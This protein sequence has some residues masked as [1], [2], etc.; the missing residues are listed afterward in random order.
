MSTSRPPDAGTSRG[1]PFFD[2]GLFLLHLNRG[3]EH[4]K[5]GLFDDARREFEDARRFRSQDP[6]VLSNLALAL[7]HL[8]HLEDAE[9]ITRSLLSSHADS[10]PLLFNL[11]LILYK[12]GRPEAR[13]P[14]ERVLALAPGH[15]KAHLTLGLLLQREGRADDAGRHLK[16]AG[17]GRT[18]F[19][20]DDT[21]SRTARVAAAQGVLAGG[22]TPAVKPD[23]F[24]GPAGPSSEPI[25]K[26]VEAVKPGVAAPHAVPETTAPA[27]GEGESPRA[28][29][30]EPAASAEP[31]GEEA[32]APASGTTQP[33]MPAL[34]RSA[35]EA[36]APPPG[37]PAPPRPAAPVIV[38][39][40]RG[41][42]PSRVPV[43]APLPRPPSHVPFASRGGGAVAADCRGGIVVRRSAL[44]GRSG[45]T[46]LVADEVLGG[47]LAGVFVRSTGS[48][49]LFLLD[50]RRHLHLVHLRDE[51]LSVD[52]ARILG[53]EAVLSYREDPAFEFRRQIPLPFVKLFGT[54]IVA[55]ATTSPPARMDVTGDFPL[56]VSARSL[57]AYGGDVEL[58]LVE[59]ADP[60]ADLG[61]GPVVAVSGTGFLLLDV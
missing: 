29:I 8:G 39:P 26:P 3:K 38:R 7:F 30:P 57:V 52:P 31:A 50:A 5:R 19:D 59:D 35:P 47:I 45:G 6:E 9:R 42:E 11:G 61:G 32:E 55:C 25:T 51:F 49:S 10:V 17:A 44:T 14:L 58:D 40:P 12:A 41:E 54:G 13:E 60:L 33:A 37:T 16:L 34:P 56:T 15:R 24:E 22:P 18:G 27:E 21:I 23:S 36:E 46:S 48:G 4:L 53:F 20:G 1:A 43:P 2:H 28:A